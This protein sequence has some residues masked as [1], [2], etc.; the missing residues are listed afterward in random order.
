MYVPIPSFES[1]K[2]WFDYWKKF[3]GRQVRIWPIRGIMRFTKTLSRTNDFIETDC[4]QS[5]EGVISEII[6]SPFGIMLKDLSL[7]DPDGKNIETVFIPMSEIAK[8]EFFKQRKE[9]P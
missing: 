5:I 6:E 9:K 4:L 8:I 7:S 1:I 2:K 3:K